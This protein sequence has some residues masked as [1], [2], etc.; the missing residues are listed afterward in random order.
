MKLLRILGAV[1][2][3]IWLSVSFAAE[4]PVKVKVNLYPMGSFE[5]VSDRII[6]SGEKKGNVYTAKEVKVLTNNLKTG[7]SLR[8]K[9]THEKLQT[10]KFPYIT[11]SDIKASGG[12]GTAKITIRDVTKDIK[13]TFKDAGA[14][15]ATADFKL[16]LKD[17]KF[18][19]INYQGVGVEDEV[20][21]I[22]TVPYTGK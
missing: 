18:A 5:M 14:G 12:T 10:D 16:S 4:G 3:S 9:H 15:K 20:Q 19:G 17:F 6:G 13:F 22:A 21:V 11:V 2:A 7:M 8:D 1:S